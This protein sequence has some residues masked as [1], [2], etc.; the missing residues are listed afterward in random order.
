MVHAS[1]IQLFILQLLLHLLFEELLSG[2]VRRG[3]RRN[4]GG[5]KQPPFAQ[6]YVQ[7]SQELE[8]GREEKVSSYTC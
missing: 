5:E 7:E 4:R 1:G 2:N 3:G 6:P 8:A